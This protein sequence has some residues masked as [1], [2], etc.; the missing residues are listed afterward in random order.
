MI[1]LD[2]FINL[3]A[4]YNKKPDRKGAKGLPTIQDIDLFKINGVIH[5][6]RETENALRGSDNSREGGKQHRVN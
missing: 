5:D 1:D 4:K 2:R 6:S 3:Q